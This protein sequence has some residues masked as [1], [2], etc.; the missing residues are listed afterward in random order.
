MLVLPSIK[1]R[2]EPV[3]KLNFFLCFSSPFEFIYRKIGLAD[4]CVGFQ[5][6]CRHVFNRQK[7]VQSKKGVRNRSIRKKVLSYPVP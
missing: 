6:Q 2:M 4:F 1:K 5:T 3:E 7:R